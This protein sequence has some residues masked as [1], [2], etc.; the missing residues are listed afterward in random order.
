[1]IDAATDLLIVVGKLQGS[2][3][4]PAN[5]ASPILGIE[6][7]TP[8]ARRVSHPVNAVVRYLSRT[9][10]LRLLPFSCTMS[11]LVS[12]ASTLHRTTFVL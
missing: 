10:N 5:P 2:I 8:A 6:C 11:C 12:I 7:P 4:S 3:Q 9:G 1:M